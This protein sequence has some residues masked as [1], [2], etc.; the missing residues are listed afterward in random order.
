MYKD[1]ECR[2]ENGRYGPYIKYDKQNVKIPK[3]LHGS[4][5][6]IKDK[7]RVKMIETA[8]PPS[9]FKRAWGKK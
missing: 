4:I 9:T 5:K 1:V 7:D 8:P 2:V 6:D 3:E